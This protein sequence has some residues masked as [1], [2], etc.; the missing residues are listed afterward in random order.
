LWTGP[1]TEGEDSSL[2]TSNHSAAGP[3]ARTGLQQ[4]ASVYKTAKNKED[5]HRNRTICF[6]F[7]QQQKKQRGHSPY[8]NNLLNFLQ[9]QKIMRTHR[10]RTICFIFLQQQ[11]IK[12]THRTRTICFIFL[13]QQKIKRTLTVPVTKMF[14]KLK[15]GLQNFKK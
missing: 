7:L 1:P 10:T 9:Q 6:I 2:S 11:K 3:Q 15:Y 12:R 13:Q 14:N 5:T 8:L 4:F